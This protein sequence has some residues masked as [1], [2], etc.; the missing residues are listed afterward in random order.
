[1]EQGPQ[2]VTVLDGKDVTLSCRAAGAPAPNITWI[3]NG[4]KVVFNQFFAVLTN[5]FACISCAF[6]NFPGEQEVATSSRVQI[7]DT[8]D[9]L[10]AAVKDTDAGQ[11][12]CIRANEAGSVRGAA[13]LG[14]LGQF[15]CKTF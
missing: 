3:Y 14:V 15:A 12:T 6:T 9:L 4:K 5:A 7:L 11:Y 10:I 13:H 1:M 8:G 2:N